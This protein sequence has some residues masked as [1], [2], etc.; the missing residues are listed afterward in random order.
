VLDGRFTVVAQAI[1]APKGRAAAARF[2]REFVEDAKT[3]G[4]V[5]E[6]V[7]ASGIRGVTVA[8]SAPRN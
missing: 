4:L 8:P 1:G 3:S 5:S 6:A 7:E 2:L